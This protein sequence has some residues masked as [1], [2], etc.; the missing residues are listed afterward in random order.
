M[1]DDDVVT[2]CLKE[3]M[4][5]IVLF[6]LRRRAITDF[7]TRASTKYQDRVRGTLTKRL[8]YRTDLEMLDFGRWMGIT[9]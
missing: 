5:A 2:V 4:M 9:I 7:M 8:V 6:S 3:R 1:N